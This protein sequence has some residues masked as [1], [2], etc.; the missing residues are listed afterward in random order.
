MLVSVV[1]QSESAICN[2]DQILLSVLPWDGLSFHY[3]DL[4]GEE[5]LLFFSPCFCVSG[6]APS[7]GRKAL[8]R[9]CLPSPTLC[10]YPQVARLTLHTWLVKA[11]G[12]RLHR[13]WQGHDPLWV[14][15]GGPSPSAFPQ[16]W[17][18]TF[19]FPIRQSYFCWLLIL[20]G[21]ILTYSLNF[22]LIDFKVTH[23]HKEGA[24]G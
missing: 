14:T 10:P 13:D 2:P 12:R 20:T 1:Q 11:W 23:S 19:L 5:T 18:Q 24:R 17:L 16:V 7:L 3:P 8:G 4:S 9:K 21:C 6:S 22:F 15:Q